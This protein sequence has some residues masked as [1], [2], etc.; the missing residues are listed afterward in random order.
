MINTWVK[1][2]SNVGVQQGMS[3]P[4]IKKRVVFNWS[5]VLTILI[6]IYG[7]LYLSFSK[8]T[9]LR[10]GILLVSI[11]IILVAVVAW[12]LL[13]NGQFRHSVNITFVLFPPLFVVLSVATHNMLVEVYLLILCLVAFFLIKKKRH[14]N[15]TFL[16]IMSCFITGHLMIS[17]DQ[18]PN[19]IPRLFMNI[20][21]FLALYITLDAVRSYSPSYLAPDS[22]CAGI[23]DVPTANRNIKLQIKELEK[24]VVELQ[25]KVNTLSELNQIKTV[26]FS[27]LAH[28][29]KDNIYSL[30]RNLDIAVK[31]DNGGSIF[32]E[33]LPLLKE[34]TDNTVY[35]LQ[36]LLHWSKTLLHSTHAA[37]VVVDINNGIS[38][39]VKLYNHIAR[40]K[41][42]HFV[43]KV[44]HNLTVFA[45]A[46]MIEVVLR[47]VVANA[48]KY[49]APGFPISIFAEKKGDQVQISV[50]DY[51]CGIDK[52]ELEMLTG[53]QTDPTDNSGVRIGL[54]LLLC[55]ELLQR[56][57]STIH[58]TSTKG[59]GTKVEI[60]IPVMK[61]EKE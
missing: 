39:V 7:L 48:V 8:G 18:Y 17:D 57:N 43:T 47:N 37:P 19:Y 27:V 30:N 61:K 31:S 11:S 20:A 59:M 46:N 9:A 28:D 24:E 4:A 2:V 10:L 14:I 41:D 29:L 58:I 56:N 25:Q 49:N 42:V 21:A 12:V 15:L 5:N 60:A 26:L 13:H 1:H 33:V 35:L 38:E 55:R 51:G 32:K 52:S 3:L 6:A 44:E 16:Y 53:R 23:E 22:S 34:E 54:G 40:E 36:R 50:I 45:D